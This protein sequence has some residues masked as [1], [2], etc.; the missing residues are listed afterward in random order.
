MGVSAPPAGGPLE[1]MDIDILGLL[2]MIATG[3]QYVVIIP[4]R[5]S[6]LTGV[7]LTA[8]V[9]SKQVGTILLNNWVMPYGIPLYGLPDNGP[10]FVSKFFTTIFLFPGE[11]YQNSLSS[12]DKWED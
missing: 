4:D 11:A 10:E 8:K 5:L 3:S 12:V 9:N 1:F 7:I 6:K 2:P